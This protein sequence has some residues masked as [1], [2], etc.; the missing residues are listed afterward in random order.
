MAYD[1]S[2][3]YIDQL[4]LK[5]SSPE[6]RFTIGSSNYSE[7]V[8]KW[9][10]FSRLANRIRA[11]K[12]TITLANDDGLFNQF[13]ERLWTLPNTCTIEIG[14]TH[15][16]SDYE[17]I[18]I[19]SGD[20]KEVRYP[21]KSSCQLHLR[22][23][24]W[25]LT[26]QKIGTSEAPIEISDQIPSDIAWTICT[27]YG[28][29]DNTQSAANPHI[30]WE[31]FEVWAENFS[32]DNVEMAARYKGVK[33]AKALDDLGVMTDSAIWTEGDGKLYFRRYTEPNSLDFTLIADQILDVEITVDGMN[34]VNKAWVYG[35]YSEESDYWAINVA[36]QQT[37]SVNTFGLHET[38]WNSKNIWY[39]DSASCQN[40]AQRKALANQYPPKRF[41]LSATITGLHRQ[42]GE[43]VRFVD[44]FYNIN[45][46]TGWRFD[47]IKIDLEK[48]RVNYG[49][50]EANAGD[51]FYLDVDFLDGDKLLL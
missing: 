12:T 26:E 36:Q 22:D 11:S 29:L 35:D 13:H 18:S 27:C 20:I 30:N 5:A 51:A 9:P 16:D 6:R 7:R 17:S 34:L 4:K 40:M 31:S 42:L 48:F 45:S 39:V 2:S 23:R 43:T 47:E 1:V 33:V 28:Q 32:T 15:P 49:M 14:F 37:T 38:I 3:W 50:N 24:L 41:K 19:F 46:G 21:K 44:E 25:S 10:R 8:V